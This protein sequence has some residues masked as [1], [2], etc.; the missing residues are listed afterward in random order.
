MSGLLKSS[1]NFQSS[2]ESKEED[3]QNRRQEEIKHRRGN[4]EGI[5]INFN[6]N[7]IFRTQSSET[8]IYHQAVQPQQ[9][10][11]MIKQPLNRLSSSS[12]ENVMLDS[13]DNLEIEEGVLTNINKN[14]LLPT[15]R[16]RSLGQSLD[17]S[18]KRSY[19]D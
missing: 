1:S 10:T 15:D 4:I 7:S 16:S 6:N 19:E 11:N 8:M 5:G 3:S 9:I 14:N 17:N 12:E 18:R 13:S 2:K